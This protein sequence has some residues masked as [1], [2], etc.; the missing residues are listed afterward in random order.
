MTNNG[1]LFETVIQIF[2]GEFK[3]SES[4]SIRKDCILT[5]STG[6]KRELDILIESKVN[7][8]DV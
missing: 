1:Q 3:D 5:D 8:F 6:L 2:Q 4:T 7:N